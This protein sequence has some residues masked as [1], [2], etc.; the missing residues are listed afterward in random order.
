[1]SFNLRNI[2]TVQTHDHK[3]T[4]TDGVATGVVFTLAG[5][6]HPVRKAARLAQTRKLM[7]AA[8]KTGRVQM[9]DP[10]EAEADRIKLIA[11]AVVGWS[12]YADDDG[13]PVPYTPEA[14]HALL[15]DP[16][17]SWLLTQIEI[18]QGNR[19]NFTKRAA[20]N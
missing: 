19:A 18:E 5:E 13:N 15:A 8:S 2:K 12:G 4:D 7:D 9:P 11:T 20:V 14:A 1:M 6:T 10:E 17:M 3:V 16:D